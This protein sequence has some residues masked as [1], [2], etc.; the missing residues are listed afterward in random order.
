V[1]GRLAMTRY[2]VTM[3]RGLDQLTKVGYNGG[4]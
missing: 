2:E 3:G 4:D 1:E